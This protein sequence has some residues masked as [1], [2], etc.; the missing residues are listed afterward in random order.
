MA[1]KN[2]IISLIFVFGSCTFLRYAEGQRYVVELNEDNWT[3]M[4]KNEWMV[5]L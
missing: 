4:L 1:N 2:V 3:E 5:E